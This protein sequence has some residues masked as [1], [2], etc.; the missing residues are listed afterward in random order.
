MTITEAAG[1]DADPSTADD[2][3]TTERLG[4]SGAGPSRSMPE[5]RQAPVGGDVVEL[6]ATGWPDLR[7][8]LP[9]AHT[10]DDRGRCRGCRVPG[11][12]VPGARWPCV[13]AGIALAAERRADAHVQ[14]L[15]PS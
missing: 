9:A 7:D 5:R 13:L 15:A 8:R 6:L 10:A 4:P 11:Y 2:T 3:L 12:G 14:G 1:D